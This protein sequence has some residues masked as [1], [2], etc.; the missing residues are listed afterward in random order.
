[1]E[2]PRKGDLGNSLTNPKP[3]LENNQYKT[4]S[5]IEDT[6]TD[7]GMEQTCQTTQSE[8]Y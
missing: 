3:G 6:L 5:L 8:F 2:E 4:G 7:P 1:L